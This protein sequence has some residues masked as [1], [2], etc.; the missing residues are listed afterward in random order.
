MPG[1]ARAIWNYIN[2]PIISNS[3]AVILVAIIGFGFTNYFQCKT[4][5]LNDSLRLDMLFSE[6]TARHSRLFNAIQANV[7]QDERFSKIKTALDPAA[8]YLYLEFKGKDEW[9]VRQEFA[10]IVQ[11]S[12]ILSKDKDT[13]GDPSK[14]PPPKCDIENIIRQPDLSKP[15]ETNFFYGFSRPSSESKSVAFRGWLEKATE[16]SSDS[17][18]RGEFLDEMD[19]NKELLLPFKKNGL[20]TD[21][22]RVMTALGNAAQEGRFFPPKMCACRAFWP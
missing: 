20:Q 18:R 9:E 21:Q 1:R 5:T 14:S 12:D 3:A 22:A 6:I 15:C 17:I 19:S 10:R 7:V 16:S 8:N 11:K 13:H 4:Q 2:Q